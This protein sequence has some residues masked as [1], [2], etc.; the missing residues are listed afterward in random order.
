MV[1][2]HLRNMLVSRISMSEIRSHFSAIL[3]LFAMLLTSPLYAQ[4]PWDNGRLRISENHRYLVHENGTPFF[5]LGNTAWL[6]PHRCKR[7]EVDF[8]LQQEKMAGFNVEQ[9]QVINAIPTTNDYG[10]CANDSSFVM[11]R[12]CHQDENG[13]WEL[14]K[15]QQERARNAVASNKIGWDKSSFKLSGSPTKFLGYDCLKC[16]AKLL[17]I[18]KDGQEFFQSLSV[19]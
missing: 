2:N 1:L 7:E 6:L 3:C 5:W 10:A 15:Q 14:M 4:K 12:F 16:R 17:H 11:E 9:I 19:H 18:F 13:F 8:F